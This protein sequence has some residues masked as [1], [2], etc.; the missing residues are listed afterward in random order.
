MYSKTSFRFKFEGYMSPGVSNNMGVNQGGNASGFL[1]RKYLSDLSEF[2]F[3]KHGICIGD[4]IIA[5]LLWA[6]DLILVL[7][8]IHI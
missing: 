3:L 7:S 5:H 6:D 4:S 8:L 2:L 1:F